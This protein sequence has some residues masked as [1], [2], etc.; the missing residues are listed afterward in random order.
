M[1]KIA[2]LGCGQIGSRHLQALALL[3]TPIEIHLVDPSTAAL[4]MSKH[5]F[6][7]VAPEAHRAQFLLTFHRD[8]KEL[9]ED[10][11]A[12][13]ISSDSVHRAEL[14][15]NLL[16]VSTPHFLLLEKF[17]FPKVE[18]YAKIEN[19]LIEKRVPSFV[20][21]WLAAVP[22]FHKVLDR[23]GV[24]ID[25]DTKKCMLNCP[26]RMRVFGTGWGLC[27]NAVHY[28]EPFQFITSRN[29]LKLLNTDF[30]PVIKPSKRPGYMEFFGKISI[31]ADDSSILEMECEDG[32]AS[33]WIG[34]EIQ[35]GEHRAN[36]KFFMDRFECVFES[37]NRTWQETLPIPRQ[38]QLTNQILDKFF[39]TGE[40][41]LP[42]ISVSSAQH[43]LVFHPFLDHFR[44]HQDKML[45][46]NQKF[47][48]GFLPI[49]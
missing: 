20:N 27:C 46:Y 47:V 17:L 36:I 41:D 42:D 24:Q 34:I 25:Y 4:E 21:Q 10:L 40:C 12:A 14:C 11:D 48:E 3:K 30:S 22:S 18:D 6:F 1:L 31:V 45:Q 13:I 35:H 16:S 33:D 19:L 38:S 37:S 32:I 7:E 23:L 44:M 28:I 5:R 39:Q 29:T 15:T 43:Q 49:T 2:I 9:P 8:C 26:I